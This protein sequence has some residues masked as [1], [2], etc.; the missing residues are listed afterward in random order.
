V[1]PTATLTV[2]V[3][4][5]DEFAGGITGLVPKVQVIGAEQV[6]LSV[7]AEVKPLVELTV[8]LAAEPEVA[9]AAIVSGEGLSATVKSALLCAPQSANLKEPM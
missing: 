5:A 1:V 3:V 8:T 7:T 2:R 9:P 6:E 4:D